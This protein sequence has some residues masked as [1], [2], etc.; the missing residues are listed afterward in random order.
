MLW[1]NLFEKGAINLTQPKGSGGFNV[2][3]QITEKQLMEF[4]NK[5]TVG[6]VLFIVFHGFT[7]FEV[8]QTATRLF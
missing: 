1:N 8:Y 2:S 4:S 7:G 3:I 6:H 5:K